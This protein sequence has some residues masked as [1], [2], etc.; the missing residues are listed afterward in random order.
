M[1]TG[2]LTNRANNDPLAF[3]AIRRQTTTPT[4]TLYFLSAAA[5]APQAPLTVAIQSQTLGAGTRQLPNAVY[6]PEIPQ[7]LQV[8]YWSEAVARDIAPV[9]MSA[10]ATSGTLLQT[11]NGQATTITGLGEAENVLRSAMTLRGVV[12]ALRQS[13]TQVTLALTVATQPA[14]ADPP[15]LTIG[16]TN[17]AATDVALYASAPFG[18][19]TPTQSSVTVTVP[20]AISERPECYCLQFDGTVTFVNDAPAS[21]LTL[22]RYFAPA[23]LSASTATSWVSDLPHAVSNTANVGAAHVVVRTNGGETLLLVRGTNTTS[24]LYT[25]AVNAALTSSAL[26]NPVLPQLPTSQYGTGSIMA[27][28]AHRLILFSNA[29]GSDAAYANFVVVNCDTGS[30]SAPAPTNIPANLLVYAGTGASGTFY[31]AA[32]T[33]DTGSSTTIVRVYTL[34]ETSGPSYSW[35]SGTVVMWFQSHLGLTLDLRA[36]I[37]AEDGTTLLVAVARDVWW[38]TLTLV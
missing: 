32:S 35:D 19:G 14:C 23:A 30:I 16:S 2:V 38:Y 37:D 26:L 17:P 12:Q 13:S 34:T 5:A 28:G 6:L 8:L 22:Y 31:V 1:A 18:S 29:F 11:S 36:D 9:L 20:G 25:Y 4:P 15:F 33:Y 3:V 10:T 27:W 24:Y 21:D 7:S